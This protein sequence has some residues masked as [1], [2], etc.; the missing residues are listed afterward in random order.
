MDLFDMTASSLSDLQ[1]RR[2]MLDAQHPPTSPVGSP[3][4]PSPSSSPTDTTTTTHNNNSQSP[5]LT[6]SYAPFLD[7]LADGLKN[8]KDIPTLVLGVQSDILFPVD[9]QRDFAEALR[10]AG[11]SQVAYFELGGVWGLVFFPTFPF[12]SFLLIDFPPFFASFVR[13]DTF[14]IDQTN[15]GGALRGFLAS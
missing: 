3:S 4:S 1:S 9:Q 12:F 8:L 7:D 13:H 11:N 5:P 6:T 14:L 15:V 2:A 10:R